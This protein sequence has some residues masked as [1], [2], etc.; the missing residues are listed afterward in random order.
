M[1]RIVTKSLGLVALV[2]AFTLSAATSEAAISLRLDDG[3]G[4]AATVTVTDGG[5]GDADLLV[6]GAITFIGTLGTWNL[7]VSTGAGSAITGPFAID[8]NSIN[9]TSGAGTMTIDFT[10][11]NFVAPGP[12]FGT[13]LLFGGT[14]TAPAGSTV[15]GSAWGDD[16]N[17]LFGMTDPAGS[18]GPFG[19]GAFSGS[20]G[21]DIAAT[22]TFSLTER[23]AIVTTGAGQFSG[24]LNLSVPEP[25][26]LS[27]LGLGLAGL[28]ARRRRTV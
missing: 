25:I 22:G 13:T 26:T 9:N 15:T 28:A 8:L 12:V 23:I 14:L 20:G 17:A 19:P 27:L 24:D 4:G 3:P 21:G 18:V 2:G 5:A 16:G 1:N 10:E 7:N 11:S 6:N